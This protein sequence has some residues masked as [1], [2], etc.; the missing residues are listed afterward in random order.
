LTIRSNICQSAPFLQAE[1]NCKLAR[2]DQDQRLFSNGVTKDDFCSRMKAGAVVHQ[3]A[4]S[5]SC[6]TPRPLVYELQVR[7][8]RA[9]L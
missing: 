5:S 6:T 9:C 4:N 7:S 8:L 2:K 1:V 3:A